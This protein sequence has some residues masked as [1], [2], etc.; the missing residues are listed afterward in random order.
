MNV[1]ATPRT[2]HSSHLALGQNELINHFI[3]RWNFFLS[4]PS[5]KQTRVV[6]P[7]DLQLGAFRQ[8]RMHGIHGLERCKLMEK[9][10]LTFTPHPSYPLLSISK[11]K[12]QSL[13]VTRV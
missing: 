10:T 1:T 9:K 7:I 6:A 2:R 13:A 12:I 3:A 8:D 11:D 4:L 5:F